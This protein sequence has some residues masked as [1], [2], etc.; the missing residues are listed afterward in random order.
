[1]FSLIRLIWTL[2]TFSTC[3]IKDEEWSC[4]EFCLIEVT[5]GCDSRFYDLSKPSISTLIKYESGFVDF[6]NGY[7]QNYGNP[8]HKRRLANEF[9]KMVYTINVDLASQS[10]I[11]Q[12]ETK[13][14]TL[15]LLATYIKLNTLAK[16]TIDFV[17]IP[18]YKGVYRTL[19][20]VLKDLD[21]N[22]TQVQ[23]S[24]NLK[25]VIV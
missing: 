12:S 11:P 25:D 2:F 18:E 6:A 19:E 7:Y 17:L 14:I 15:R 1:M 23:G 10:Q 9:M 8:R 3:L 5:A 24:S 4:T 22:A 20:W 16:E 13:W 21:R